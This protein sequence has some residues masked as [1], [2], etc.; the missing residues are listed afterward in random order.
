MLPTLLLTKK[1]PRFSQDCKNVFQGICRKQA[2]LKYTDSDCLLH[3]YRVTVHQKLQRNCLVG[4]QQEYILHLFT[5][6]MAF[7]T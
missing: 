1:T 4:T 7:C 3:I 5:C 6:H 2:V